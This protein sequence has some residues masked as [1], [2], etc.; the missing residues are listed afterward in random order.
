MTPTILLLAGNLCDERLWHGGSGAIVDALA[1]SEWLI[2]RPPLAEP[3][4]EA[5]AARVAATCDGPLLPIG[6]SLGGIVALA[7]ARMVP[8]RI[9][10]IG[11][12]D[13]NAGSDLPERA[14]VRPR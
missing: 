4:I 14:A 2:A 10:A 12:I 11:L 8:E 1:A 5:M 9:A 7:L 13:T 6:F 3:T